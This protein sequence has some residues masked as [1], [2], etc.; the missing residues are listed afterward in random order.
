M[1]A[2]KRYLWKETTISAS[3]NRSITKYL[4]IVDGYTIARV[5]T[6]DKAYV[7]ELDSIEGQILESYR[8]SSDGVVTRRQ[9]SR[10]APSSL[11][12][13]SL[14]LN[15][16]LGA[17]AMMVAQARRIHYIS[18]D[19]L[20]SHELAAIID[21]HAK[22]VERVAELQHALGIKTLRNRSN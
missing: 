3:G 16:S 11:R 13:I 9:S 14:N 1:S 15:Q 5:G 20:Q 21:Y 2:I 6:P 7:Y 18:R 17:A 12:P 22:I 10:S 4:T 8:K 19:L